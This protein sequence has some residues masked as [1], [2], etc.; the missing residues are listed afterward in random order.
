VLFT[1]DVRFRAMA[2]GWQRTGR[3]FGGLVF[4]AQLGGTIGEFVRDLQLI[5]EASNTADWENVVEFIPFKS[6]PA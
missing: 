6:R 2:E 3:P 5:A 4:G 1:Q